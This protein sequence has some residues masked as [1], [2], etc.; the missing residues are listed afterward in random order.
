MSRWLLYALV[1]VVMYGMFGFLAGFNDRDEA[2]WLV[3][4]ANDHLRRSGFDSDRYRE[5]A[6][7]GRNPRRGVAFAL[8]VS[9]APRTEIQLGATCQALHADLTT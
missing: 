1:S 5:G 2:H 3:T 9:S 6:F 4:S 8:L 7:S